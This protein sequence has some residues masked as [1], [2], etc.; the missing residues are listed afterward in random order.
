DR[1]MKE[2]KERVA[3]WEASEKVKAEAAKAKAAAETPPNANA[4]ATTPAI[5]KPEAPPKPVAPAVPAVPEEKKDVS[6]EVGTVNYI[7]SNHGGGISR[8]V[9]NEHLE[10]KKKGTKIVLNEFGTIPIGTFSEDPDKDS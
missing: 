2:Y 8:V 10:D 9:L 7:F 1:E 6:S 5:E 4:Q 3:K